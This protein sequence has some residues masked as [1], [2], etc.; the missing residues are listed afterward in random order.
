MVGQE[1]LPQLKAIVGED[2]HK[3][4]GSVAVVVDLAEV[5]A[6]VVVAAVVVE[7]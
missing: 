3:W 5:V 6:V 2:L 4:G 7:A 1:Q